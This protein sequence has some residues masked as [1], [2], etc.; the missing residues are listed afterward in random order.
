MIII[1]IFKYNIETI[2]LDNEIL[3]TKTAYLDN[4]IN[5]QSFYYIIITL[6]LIAS[7]IKIVTLI[8]PC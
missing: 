6:N 3:I 5:C 7:R 4:T 8:G 1:T 2:I